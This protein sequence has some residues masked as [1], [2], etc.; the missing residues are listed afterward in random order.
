LFLLQQLAL[1]IHGFLQTGWDINILHN[2]LHK[3]LHRIGRQ[4][5]GATKILEQR[6][7]LHIKGNRILQLQLHTIIS[8][9]HETLQLETLLLLVVPI[10]ED[11]GHLMVTLNKGRER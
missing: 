9:I 6:L 11:C 8:I 10:I 2:P 3:Q 7:P 5:V 1:P 4:Q